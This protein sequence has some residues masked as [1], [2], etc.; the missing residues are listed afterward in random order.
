MIERYTERKR[1]KHLN[2]SPLTELVNAGFSLNAEQDQYS[3]V[4][5]GYN[6]DIGFDFNLWSGSYY[7]TRI[8]I[9]IPSNSETELNSHIYELEK[10]YKGETIQWTFTSINKFYP[11][12][13]S[14]PKIDTMISDLK[15]SIRFL[16]ENNIGTCSMEEAN[17]KIAELKK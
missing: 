16:Q 17:K 4:I 5:D 11:F 2:S 3:G 7:W 9:D 15:D 8:F 6:C 12:I 1:K 10:N 14:R 13:F